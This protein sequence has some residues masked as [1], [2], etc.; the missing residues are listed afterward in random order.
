MARGRLRYVSLNASLIPVQPE[1]AL[2]LGAPGVLCLY[3]DFRPGQLDTL[4][5]LCNAGLDALSEVTV[6]IDNTSMF[7]FYQSEPA[8]RWANVHATRQVRWDV[9]PPGICVLI[10]TLSHYIWDEVN[11]YSLTFTDAAGQRR[12]A[13]AHDLTLNACRLAQDPDKVWVAFDAA[14]LVN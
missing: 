7:S 5:Y 6:V 2:P 13:K 12:T 10:N 11:R 8:K 4:V 9:V 14:L 3:A 1:I